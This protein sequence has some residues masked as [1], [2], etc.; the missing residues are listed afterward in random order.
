MSFT[1]K[2]KV[3]NGMLEIEHNDFKALWAHASFAGDFPEKCG[4]CGS[5]NIAPMHKTPKGNEYFGLKCR[6]CGAE[7]T[8]HQRKEGGFY[9]RFDDEWTKYQGG[10]APQ[11]S[12][13][14]DSF[15]EDIPI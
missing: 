3:G 15:D 10:G 6:E 12:H 1:Y 7:Q 8:F 5:T 9:I 13:R 14:S 4:K 11:E 2:V